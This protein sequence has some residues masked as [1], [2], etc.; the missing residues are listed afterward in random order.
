[1]GCCSSTEEGQYI[2]KQDLTVWE[3]D[4]SGGQPSN[5]TVSAGDAVHFLEEENTWW[6]VKKNNKSG[7]ASRYYFAPKQTVM[8]HEKEPWY[9]GNITRNETN[10]MLRHELNPDGSFIIR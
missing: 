3:Y 6:K 9:F 10:V 5:F 7:Y 1:M 8:P 2:A 4:G